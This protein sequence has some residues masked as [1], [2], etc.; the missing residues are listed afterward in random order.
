MKMKLMI[1]MICVLFIGATA[2]ANKTPKN[3]KPVKTEPTRLEISK[4]KKHIVLNWRSTG[5]IKYLLEASYDLIN[6][7]PYMESRGSLNNV[8]IRDSENDG[9]MFFRVVCQLPRH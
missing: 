5:S 9:I 3:D 2:F 4:K 8:M 7:F 1:S 6:W